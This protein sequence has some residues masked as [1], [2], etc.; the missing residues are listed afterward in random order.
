MSVS[1]RWADVDPGENP[2]Q[3]GLAGA[4]GADQAKTIAI[5]DVERDVVQGAHIDAVHGVARQIALCGG[6]TSIFFSDWLPP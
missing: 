1:A 4:I 5:L 3:R 2:Q 6:A